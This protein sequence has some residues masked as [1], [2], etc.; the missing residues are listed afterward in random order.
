MGKYWEI[1][2]GRVDS[3]RF[4]ET[5]WRRFPEATTL[6]VE[7]GSIARNVKDCYRT[8]REEGDYLP[9][10]QTVF[11]RSAKFRCRFSANLVDALSALA[12]RHAEPELLDHLALYIDS[13]EVVV[14][15]DAFANSI[16]VAP[17]VPES[18]VS[19]FATDL[20]LEY[21]SPWAG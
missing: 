14:W 8:H 3:A 19:S 7:G 15:H 10:A 6:Y 17:T 16:L 2:E 1:R 4:F 12:G 11:P 5:L 20:G 21:R 18:V 13:D 9:R